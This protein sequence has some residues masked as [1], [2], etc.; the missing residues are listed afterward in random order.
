VLGRSKLLV[1]AARL[2]AKE[3]HRA[4]V[5]AAGRLEAVPAKGT[6]G[7]R[8]R[9]RIAGVVVHYG[10]F[11]ALAAS[12]VAFFLPAA[13]RLGQGKALGELV[14]GV[15][16]TVE[17]LLLVFN[18]HGARWRLVSRWVERNEARSNRPT[19]MLDAMRWR[20]FG[21]ALFALGL[22]WVAVGVV[23]LGQGASDLF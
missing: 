4:N 8:R 3:A 21:Y 11:L 19:G 17:G 14:V 18:W 2:L 9:G 5:P 10:L 13:G 6:I 7:G 12:A 20:L 15:I 23:E 22:A 1:S 16:L